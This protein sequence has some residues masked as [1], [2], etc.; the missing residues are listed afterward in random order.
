MRKRRREP[1]IQLDGHLAQ[2]VVE[3]IVIEVHT[4]ERIG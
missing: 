4:A 3:I 1:I 2:G